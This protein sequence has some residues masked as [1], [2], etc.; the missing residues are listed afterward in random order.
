MAHLFF[1]ACPSSSFMTTPFI[2]SSLR[3]AFCPRPLFALFPSP[4]PGQAWNHAVISVSLSFLSSR[5]TRIHLVFPLL[6]PR[7]SL[8]VAH[9]IRQDVPA[10]PPR[11]SLRTRR[12][13]PTGHILLAD[14]GGSPYT[15][16]RGEPALIS[17]RRTHHSSSCS[18]R[19]L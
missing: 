1:L 4:I 6:P 2:P 3:S 5:T 13:P 14:P 19:A 12:P 18:P 16:P 17:I 7:A 8:D 15:L 11:Q 9:F 10:F